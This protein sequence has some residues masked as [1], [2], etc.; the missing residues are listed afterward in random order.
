[1]SHNLYIITAA[2]KSF[3]V[4]IRFTLQVLHAFI[5]INSTCAWPLMTEYLPAAPHILTEMCRAKDALKQRAGPYLK[6]HLLHFPS[7]KH[8]RRRLPL[9]PARS[10]GMAQPFPGDEVG[11]EFLKAC[12][13]FILLLT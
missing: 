11:H 5:E 9:R 6:R 4:G 1:M 13:A 3:Q 7:C 2:A 8:C 10:E 12:E